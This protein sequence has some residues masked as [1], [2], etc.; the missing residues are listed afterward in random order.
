MQTCVC[1]EILFGFLCI[2]RYQNCLTILK[3]ISCLSKNYLELISKVHSPMVMILGDSPNAEFPC[4]CCFRMLCFLISLFWM[5]ATI[6]LPLRASSNEVR[7]WERAK[8]QCWDRCGGGATLCSIGWG[9][10]DGGT[11]GRERHAST[12]NS[13]LTASY[14]RW[15]GVMWFLW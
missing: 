2:F 1:K 14:P 12:R 9:Y 5:R 10:G 13:V 3:A 11:S 8:L 4:C 6:G 15:R 7:V